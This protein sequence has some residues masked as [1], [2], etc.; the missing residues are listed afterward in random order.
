MTREPNDIRI[1]DLGLIDYVAAWERMKAF[2]S[3]R[4]ADTAD[5]FWWL[6]HHPVYTQGLNCRATTLTAT[7]IPIV[8]SDRG[9]Q[10]TY[11]GPGQL[12]GYALIDIK[13]R[14]KGVRW[15]VSLLEQAVIDLLEGFQIRGEHRPGAPG[16]Y[17]RQ[18]KIAALGLRV[19]RGSSYHGLSVNVDM[20]LQ[21]FQNIDPCGYKDLEVTQL[22]D[23]GVSVS[24]DGVRERLEDHVRR[25][26]R[27][28][29]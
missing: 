25:L 15:L 19:R 23:L 10:M 17:V 27:E 7:D 2:N 21:P 9:G 18:R 11:H 29:A 5:E 26:L 6:Q 13:R 16:V 12:V 22:R 3:S 4:C 14:G 20:D 24:I 1:R 8:A 28:F